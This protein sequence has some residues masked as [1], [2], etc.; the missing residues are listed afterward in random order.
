MR[1]F[2]KI[3]LLS[4]FYTNT[5]IVYHNWQQSSEIMSLSVVNITIDICISNVL[6]LQGSFALQVLKIVNKIYDESYQKLEY[7]IWIL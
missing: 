3:S 7:P 2:N 6:K 4:T 1:C 5:S